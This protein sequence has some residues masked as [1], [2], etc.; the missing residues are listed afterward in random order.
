M[1]GRI[2]SVSK[3]TADSSLREVFNIDHEGGHLLEVLEEEMW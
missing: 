3:T 2:L 1:A